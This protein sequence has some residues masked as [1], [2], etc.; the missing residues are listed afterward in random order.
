VRLRESQRIAMMRCTRS[1]HAVLHV[2]NIRQKYQCE[3]REHSQ[4]NDS[5]EGAKRKCRQRNEKHCEPPFPQ[6]R[7][8]KKQRVAAPE[9]EAAFCDGPTRTAEAE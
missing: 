4:D 8:T 9:P 1:S 3:D 6:L 5:T 2:T 7:G